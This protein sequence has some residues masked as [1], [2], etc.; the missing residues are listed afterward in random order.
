M[1]D[2]YIFKTERRE[3]FLANKVKDLPSINAENQIKIYGNQIWASG[4]KI[5]EVMKRLN[6]GKVDYS[7]ACTYLSHEGWEER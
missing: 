6:E 5:A 3:D 1:P 7:I 2:I 4:S